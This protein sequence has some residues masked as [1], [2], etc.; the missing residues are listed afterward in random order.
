MV[1]VDPTVDVAQQKLP[2]FDGDTELQDHGVAP[3]VEFT[4]Y[5]NE[6]LG[7][8]CE[9]S[10]LYLVCRQRVTEEVVKV[11]CSLVVQRVRLCRWIFF[12][13]HDTR[14]GWSRRLVSPR[15]WIR[16]A[17]IGPFQP[18][19]AQRGFVLVAGEDTHWH[20]LSAGCRLRKCVSCLVKTPWDVIELKA[21]KFVLQPSDFSAVCS[22]LG[23]VVAR[24]LHDLV[25][26]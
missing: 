20:W 2:L 17:I 6:G 13:L 15:G 19:I 8:T 25:D 10:S 18:F 5:K 14:T 1:T 24:L 26:D 11:E 4:F 7:A 12:K 9:P 3:F 21:I 16:W 23:I 22:H